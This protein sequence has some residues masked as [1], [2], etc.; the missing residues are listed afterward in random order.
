MRILV[1]E[2]GL[3]WEQAED[4]TIRSVAY[5]NHTIM[6]EALERWPESM[7]R[8]VLP[9]IYAILQELNRR[10]CARLLSASRAS[11][12]ASAVWRSWRTIRCIWPTCVS[13]TAT[14]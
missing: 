3:S 7:M 12:T 4:L 14:A 11:G 6:P 9:R 2:E 10:L 1:D 13:R 5:T 8:D